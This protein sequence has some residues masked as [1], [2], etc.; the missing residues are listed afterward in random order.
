MRESGGQTAVSLLRPLRWFEVGWMQGQTLNQ[1]R[2]LSDSTRS[3]GPALSQ[4]A[5]AFPS[6]VSFHITTRYWESLVCARFVRYMTCYH[7]T[8]THTHTHT[9]T[10]AHVHTHTHTHTPT[11]ACTHTHTHTHIYTHTHIHTH[12]RIHT[13]IHTH[14]Q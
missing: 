13:C 10:H 7:H 3:F 2:P 6:T 14:V 11:R 9:L 5:I 12:T 1:A 8:H 4:V